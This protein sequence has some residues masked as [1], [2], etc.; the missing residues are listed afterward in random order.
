MFQVITCRQDDT[1]IPING[2]N[3]G[4]ESW[5][6]EMVLQVQE[7]LFSNGNHQGTHRL[8]RRMQESRYYTKFSQIQITKKWMLRSKD[9]PQLPNEFTQKKHTKCQG[10]FKNAGTKTRKYTKYTQGES[11]GKMLPFNIFSCKNKRR[12]KTSKR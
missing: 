7:N 6:K 2:H 1:T 4:K 3:P 12:G 8:L 9:H 5:I 11:A 10:N